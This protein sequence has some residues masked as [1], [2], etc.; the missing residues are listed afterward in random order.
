MVQGRYPS[1]R[2]NALEATHQDEH[3]PA[4]R[5]TKKLTF[6]KHRLCVL[7]CFIVSAR[8]VEKNAANAG[9]ERR[10]AGEHC[11]GARISI[12]SNVIRPLCVQSVI[13]GGANALRVR[14]A[15]NPWRRLSMVFPGMYQL[16]R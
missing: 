12:A 4:L 5:G 2:R 15:Q 8:A 9:N 10:E 14:Q 11:T 6:E 16:C 13:G 1:L 3:G 7:V